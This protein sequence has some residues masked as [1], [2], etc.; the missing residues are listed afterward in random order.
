MVLVS[1]YFTACLAF[2][3][4]FTCMAG[5]HK[6]PVFHC[7]LLPQGALVM[8]GSLQASPAWLPPVLLS[9]GGEKRWRS[10]KAVTGLAPPP[11]APPLPTHLLPSYPETLRILPW[12]PCTP[13]PHLQKNPSLLKETGWVMMLLILDVLLSSTCFMMFVFYIKSE[14]AS[15]QRF[16]KAQPQTCH[17]M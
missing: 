2:A 7:G 5:A 6:K 17:V 12:P 16:C 3:V 14:F 13:P 4:F 8:S 1:S 15:L 9:V 10:P 11:W